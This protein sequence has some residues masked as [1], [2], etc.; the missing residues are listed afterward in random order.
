MADPPPEPTPDP[1]STTPEEAARI[2]NA[3]AEEPDW[4]ALVWTAMTICLDASTKL[5]R[6]WLLGA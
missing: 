5:S 4:H 6:C 3:A 1:Q 2:L